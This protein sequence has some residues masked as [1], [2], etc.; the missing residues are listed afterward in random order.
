MLFLP[1]NM[2]IQLN[3]VSDDQGAITWFRYHRNRIHHV[4]NPLN[5]GRLRCDNVIA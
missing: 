2:G 5:L 1:A 3:T 4:S